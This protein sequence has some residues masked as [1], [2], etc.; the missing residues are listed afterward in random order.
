MGRIVEIAEKTEVPV[1][2]KDHNILIRLPKPL[3]DRVIHQAERLCCSMNA[4]ARM[5]FIK[6]LEEEEA[7]ERS[8]TC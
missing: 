3:S 8:Q 4:L 1:V 7:K 6:F 5:A 2:K